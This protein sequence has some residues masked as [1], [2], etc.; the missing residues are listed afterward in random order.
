MAEIGRVLAFLFMCG[1]LGLIEVAACKA[2]ARAVR[3]LRADVRRWRR[4]RA[5]KRTLR[6]YEA[7]FRRAEEYEQLWRGES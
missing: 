4:H 5:D 2:L 7:E 6:D 1:V 3:E